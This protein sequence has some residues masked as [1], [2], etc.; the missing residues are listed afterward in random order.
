MK[1]YLGIAV[2]LMSAL[3]Q[4]QTLPD[5]EALLAQ[6]LQEI[7]ED[8]EVTS[9]SR[10]AQSS[11]ESMAITHII[12]DQDILQ[13]NLRSMA[14]ILAQFSGLTTRDDD[15][16]LYVGA[17]G[18]G[19]PSDF[20]AR[21]LFLLN[22]TRINENMLDASLLGNEFFVD[23]ELIDR[24][25]YSPGA[26]AALYG[27]NALLGVINIIT[28]SSAQIG[29]LEGSLNLTH[30]GDKHM[31]LTAGHRSEQGN[32]SWFSLSHIG[33]D[34]IKFGFDLFSPEDA[35]FEHLNQ[36]KSTRVT[37]SHQQGGL[38]FNA[39]GVWRER[40]YPELGL[41]PDYTE[42]IRDNSDSYLLALTYDARL[43]PYTDIYLHAST[44]G[45]DYTRSIPVQESDNSLDRVDSLFSGRW[46]NI[47]SRLIYHGLQN[48][49]WLVGLDLQQDHRQLF[50]ARS[51]SGLLQ[52]RFTNNGLRYGIYLQDHWQVA[53][54][55]ALQLALRYD[56]TDRAA[57]WS[58]SLS[59]GYQINADSR[60]LLRYNR[61]YRAANQLESGNNRYFF[62]PRLG[63]ESIST[64]EVSLKQRWSSSFTSFVTLYYSD[65]DDLIT[66][67][68]DAPVF[69][70]SPPI[71]SLG[72]EAGVSKRWAD[73]TNLVAS[74][75]VQRTTDEEF[76]RLGNSPMLIGQLRYNRPI[77][78]PD[79]V[80]SWLTQGIS[81]RITPYGRQGGY[82]SHDLNL[83]WTPNRSLDLALGIQ[84]VGN[85]RI[86][87][88]TDLSGIP[89]LQ[90]PRQAHLSVR[91][92]WAP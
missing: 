59:I 46:S 87:E 78:R 30:E 14:D 50:D 92:R 77:W 32:D 15:S 25:E 70:N 54:D 21:I 61:A 66:E 90:R 63:G 27:N 11:S 75:A 44:H 2:V 49:L 68:L 51:Q 8:T 62:A 76:G 5:L 91:W 40:Q 34:D 81:E 10:M 20:N 71:K 53:S 16:F 88:V 37:L 84:N 72:L 22:G 3:T 60:L 38:H 31:R 47:D 45:N 52:Q 65:I 12:T 82:I 56:H 13:Y 19:R 36:E 39:A 86:E 24:V 69:Y 41:V 29:T 73:G 83:V 55:L 6:P 43:T 17:R 4:G 48:H 79:L 28:K 85:K 18:I 23:V 58:P 80:F 33:R 42:V 64:S 7:P 74:L 89:T 1:R 26:A 67:Y 35:A 9:A 57:H